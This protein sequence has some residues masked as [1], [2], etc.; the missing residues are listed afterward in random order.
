[1]LCRRM[2]LIRLH[3]L[4]VLYKRLRDGAVYGFFPDLVGISDGANA[5]TQNRIAHGHTRDPRKI[6]GRR[7]GDRRRREEA[8]A[9]APFLL[10]QHWYTAGSVL[11]VEYGISEHLNCR[12]GYWRALNGR[13]CGSM[14]TQV[15]LTVP[16]GL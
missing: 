3:L 9:G 5:G 11:W 2:L 1:M 10:G 12:R 4:Q 6:C 16:K 13:T 14:M 8:V 7:D 15:R